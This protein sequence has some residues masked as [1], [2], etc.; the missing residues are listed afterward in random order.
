MLRLKLEII[1]GEE[2]VDDGICDFILCCFWKAAEICPEGNLGVDEIDP[3]IY[4]PAFD[5]CGDC[6][7]QTNHYGS[8][9]FGVHWINCTDCWRSEE[10][11]L[12]NRNHRR[13]CKISFQKG[14][15]S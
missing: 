11:N 7:M 14:Y 10:S 2:Y 4:L 9:G 6:G 1:G 5:P 8:A 12:L 15:V 13:D 3:G